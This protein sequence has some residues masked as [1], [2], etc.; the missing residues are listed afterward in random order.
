MTDPG[1]WPDSAHRLVGRNVHGRAIVTD[2]LLRDWLMRPELALVEESCAAERALA[3]S[4]QD[5]PARIVEHGE[6][7]AIVD[8][9]ARDNWFS[10]LAFRDRVLASPDIES[11]WLELFLD[12]LSGVA[13]LFVPQLTQI[14]LHG[15]LEDCEGNDGAL[16][17]RAAEL[18]FRSQQA[19]PQSGRVLLADAEVLGDYA[20][21]GGFGNIGRLI[22]QAGAV[23]RAANLDVLDADN[24][25]EL[26]RR[27]GRR[28]VLPLNFGQPALTSLC[29]V[30]ERWIAHFY[31]CAVTLTPQKDIHDDHWAWHIGLD[32]EAMDLLNTLYDGGEL[33]ADRMSRIVALFRLDFADPQDVRS[34]LLRDGE[35]RPV[36]LALA[37]DEDGLVQMKPQNLLLNLPLAA[38]N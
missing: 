1:F 24:A 21:T 31:G 14:I 36:W 13:P 12:G 32:R 25:A 7:A 29:R 3:G 22:L 9:D 18:F 15:L 8:G 4:L 27:V 6:I 19:T 11:A 2:A 38:A 34:E 26:Y 16:M 20:E 30:M 28:A 35:A 10:F 37:M 17:W 5:A 23:P 33:A